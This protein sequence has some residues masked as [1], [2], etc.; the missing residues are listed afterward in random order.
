MGN[1][2]AV[3]CSYFKG[4]DFIKGYIEDALNQSIFENVEFYFLDCA[5][6]EGESKIIEE[7][8]VYPNVHLRVLDKDPGLYAAWNICVN[9]IKEPI[10]GNWNVDDRK[11]SWSLECLRDQLIL[12]ESLDLVYGRTLISYKKNEKFFENKDKLVYPCLTHSLENLLKNNSPHCMP[13]WR[14]S[15]HE[16]FGYFDES[17]KTAADT[18]LWLRACK[19]GA[20][21]KMIND[22]VGLYF[23]N[24]T[25]RSTN[26]ETLAEM[27]KEVNYVRDK[28]R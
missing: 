2:T 25:G 10:L 12:D 27:I 5:S 19:G 11:S 20:K 28:H 22:V 23:E 18:D 17:L 4:F 1:D 6:K 15:L 9:W 24:P 3:F 8:L 14:K 13:L 21:M 7:F 16:R 26:P